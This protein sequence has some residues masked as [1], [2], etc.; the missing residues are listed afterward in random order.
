M[1]LV[2]LFTADIGT[3]GPRSLELINNGSDS[4]FSC[5]VAKLFRSNYHRA[6]LCVDNFIV[7]ASN[8]DFLVAAFVL[9]CADSFSFFAFYFKPNV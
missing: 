4:T 8:C 1:S 5:I 9:N 3:N 7:S 6:A 2:A